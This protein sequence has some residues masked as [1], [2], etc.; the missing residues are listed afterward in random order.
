MYI[1]LDSLQIEF[2]TRP[3]RNLRP[4]RILRDMAQPCDGN[5]INDGSRTFEKRSSRLATPR[6]TFV[7]ESRR[8]SAANKQ[9]SANARYNEPTHDHPSLHQEDA[10]TDEP[11]LRGV[12]SNLLLAFKF[13]R[14]CGYLCDSNHAASISAEARRKAASFHYPRVRARGS[15]KRSGQGI[16]RNE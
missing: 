1:R 10:L 13:S 14:R 7:S 4:H 11:R 15:A 6:A 3:R 16:L 9:H 8:R 5:F 12:V 2:C